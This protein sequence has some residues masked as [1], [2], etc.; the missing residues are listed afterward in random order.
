MMIHR[1]VAIFQRCKIAAFDPL[2]K[3]SFQSLDYAS[4]IQSFDVI[5]DSV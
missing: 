3:R 2:F 4:P 1:I 5:W